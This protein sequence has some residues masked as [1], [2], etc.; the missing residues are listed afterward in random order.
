MFYMPQ[1]NTVV[2]TSRF[3]SGTL[4]ECCGKENKLWEGLDKGKIKERG[5]K[6]TKGEGEGEMMQRNR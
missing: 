3:L 4:P 6:E 1:Y 5:E 2:T